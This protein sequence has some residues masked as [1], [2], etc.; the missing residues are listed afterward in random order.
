MHR[1][2]SEEKFARS[3]ICDIAWSNLP[4]FTMIALC[5]FRGKLYFALP[6]ASMDLAS[7]SVLYI[8]LFRAALIQG[9][10]GGI[11]LRL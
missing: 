6:F 9:V 10:K 5:R 1:P 7:I 4:L 8:I 11:W 2:D 3:R